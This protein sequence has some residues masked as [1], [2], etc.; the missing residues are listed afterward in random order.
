MNRVDVK[1]LLE[2]AVETTKDIRA[3]AEFLEAAMK[4]IA[5]PDVI[6]RANG[7]GDLYLI[8]NLMDES[9]RRMR[10]AQMVVRACGRELW[11]RDAVEAEV[12]TD[13]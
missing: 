7:V 1:K 4:Y 9:M 3:N 8:A 6:V 12:E 10:E 2:R 5:T 13:D 11:G